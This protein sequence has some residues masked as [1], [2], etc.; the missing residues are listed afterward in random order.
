MSKRM[1][2]LNLFWKIVAYIYITVTVVFYISIIKMNLLPKNYLIIFTIAEVLITGIVLLGVTR[3]FNNKLINYICLIVI[4]VLSGSYIVISNY[5]FATSNFL[6]NV[7][8]EGKETEDYY[9]VVRKDSEFSKISDLTGETLYAFQTSDKIKLD[10][11]NQVEVSFD[12]K[13]GLLDLGN[14]LIDNKINVVLI[15]GA[16][17]DMLVDEIES[18]KENTKIIATISQEIDTI[19][20]VAETH[21]KHRIQDDVFNVYISGIDT[22]GRMFQEVMLILL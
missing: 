13:E 5:A 18:F 4:I 21:S 9:I 7:F 10:I 14:N 3:N 17:Y 19:P 11:K 20:V 1:K 2:K 12:D 15:S 8:Q 6:N 16:Q 22:S